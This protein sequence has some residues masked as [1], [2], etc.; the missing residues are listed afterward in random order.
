MSATE[1]SASHFA[2]AAE[3]AKSLSRERERLAIALR[4]AQAGVYEWAPGQNQVWWSPETYEVFGVSA[5]TFV[6]TVDSFIGLIHPDD[7]D[8]L[9]RKTEECIAKRQVFHHEYRIIQPNGELRW[10]VNCSHV[11]HDTSGNVTRIVGA[12]LDITE[13]KLAEDK[14]RESEERFR[15]MADHSPMMLW[16]SE[17]DGRCTYLNRSWYEFTGQTPETGMGMG[18]MDVVHPDDRP[19]VAEVFAQCIRDK[20]P[21]RLEYRVRRHDGVFRWVIDSAAPRLAADGHFLGFIGSVIDITERKQAE[22]LIRSEAKR[23]EVLVQQRTAKLQD[24]VGELEA[25]SYSV[26]HDLRAPLRAMAGFTDVLLDDLGPQLSGDHRALLLRIHR[27]ATRLDRLTQDLLTYSRLARADL[28]LGP[29]DLEHVITEL[30]EQY[31][32]LQFPREK[33][34]VAA[35]LLPVLGNQALIIQVLANLLNNAEK[36]VAPGVVPRILVRTEPLGRE[37]RVWVEDNGIGIAPDHLKRLFQLFSRVHPDS[38]Y[39]GTGIGLAIVRKATERM[40]GTV[41]V[42]SE[43]GVG[44]RFWFQLPQPPS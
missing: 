42:E 8:E 22:E 21:L 34:R 19:G 25:F 27:A 35:P 12:A 44:S 32:N 36:F 41:G 40:G 5:A 26:S 28:V 6:P 38:G 13:R 15:N 30:L 39:V 23:L 2:A 24:T 10:I 3:T 7:R 4:T 29:V 11:L 1:V 20:R 43:P 17:F 18:W 16:V 9:W 33:I 14:L 31:P 37:V